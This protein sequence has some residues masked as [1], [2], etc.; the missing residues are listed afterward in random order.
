MR[1]DELSRSWMCR[2]KWRTFGCPKKPRNARYLG[3]FRTYPGWGDWLLGWSSPCYPK[4]KSWVNY[5]DQTAEVTP[6]D[7]FVRESFQNPLNSGSGIILI[8]PDWTSLHFH[9]I[10][11]GGG[12]VFELMFLKGLW[13]IGAAPWVVFFLKHHSFSMIF[14]SSPAKLRQG[15]YYLD[16]PG[17]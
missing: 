15:W 14:L 10:F 7:G 4:K 12:M 1:W 9:R 13:L 6:N 5:S 11:V 3:V 2:W 8:C 16:V 17:S